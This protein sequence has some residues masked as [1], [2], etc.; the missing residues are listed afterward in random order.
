MTDDFRQKLVNW[1]S[2]MG[3]LV[4]FTNLCMASYWFFNRPQVR[5]RTYDFDG[6]AAVPDEWNIVDWAGPMG[7]ILFTVFATG[8]LLCALWHVF[9]LI[10]RRHASD[11]PA[12]LLSSY[13]PFI[14]TLA[15]LGLLTALTVS[16]RFTYTACARNEDG[17]I[18]FGFD[19]CGTYLV[20]WI[21]WPAWIA[22][23]L[24]VALMLGKGIIAIRSLFTKAP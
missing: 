6:R 7:E 21:E 24:L 4:L 2:S 20:P 5:I 8:L 3:T 16:G 14:S 10:Q 9:D 23:L 11:Y 19:G 1:L 17:Q 15:L 13:L 12:T 18:M 22:M